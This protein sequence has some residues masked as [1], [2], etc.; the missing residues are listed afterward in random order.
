MH[1]GF[2][3]SDDPTWPR[4]FATSA[5]TLGFQSTSLPRRSSTSVSAES[6]KPATQPR[7]QAQ[8]VRMDRRS[9]HGQRRDVARRRRRG[10]RSLHRA[11]IK[12]RWQSISP[13]PR[14]A[15]RLRLRARDLD[16][17][18]AVRPRSYARRPRRGR[19]AGRAGQR[20]VDTKR[21]DCRQARFPRRGRLTECRGPD[22]NGRRR[23]SH[24][25]LLGDRH[26]FRRIV[27][28]HQ[29]TIPLHLQ[30]E[31]VPCAPTDLR[32]AVLTFVQR[33]DPA[34]QALR[35]NGA[36]RPERRS[37][38]RRSSAPPRRSP[39]P[40]P[41]GRRRRKPRRHPKTTDPL[42]RRIVP[43]ILDPSPPVVPAASY[44]ALGGASEFA[45][46]D[47]RTKRRARPCVDVGD[48]QGTAAVVSGRNRRAN[49]GYGDDHRR[50]RVR[51]SRDD[52]EPVD[53]PIV[54]SVRWGELL[55]YALRQP[56][57]AAALGLRYELAI[58]LAD[59]KRFV[60]GGW[61]FIEF[62]AGE[63]RLESSG[64]AGD[65]YACTHRVSRRSTRRARLRRPCS[66]R[67]TRPGRVS[68]TSS[69]SRRRRTTTALPRSCT[70]ISRS[71]TTRWSATSVKSGR[72][73]RYPN[74]LGRRAGVTWQNRQIAMQQA[75]AARYPGG[76]SPLGVAGYPESTSRM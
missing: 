1:Q 38:G 9:A 71:P 13:S 72:G 75:R 50:L 35:T 66:F 26:R 34:T 14:E 74:Q 23:H 8:A 57:L 37:V 16:R 63:G 70:S 67:S 39:P 29:E 65:R 5:S 64:D 61:L 49:R 36:A 3:A 6:T 59:P 33:W 53:K 20:I 4:Q 19:R 46:R 52:P 43:T 41:F 24:Q 7:A 32:L 12:P 55:S 30:Q 2:C 17:S 40:G 28:I 48:S 76:Q 44:A 62:A 22:R 25:H 54:R 73:R 27:A 51:H 68:T 69:R 56:R 45:G 42:A 31:R 58:P 11:G 15:R 60:D 18:K 10:P 47:D 21:R